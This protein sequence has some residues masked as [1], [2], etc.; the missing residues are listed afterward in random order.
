MFEQRA[1]RRSRL[2]VLPSGLQFWI[3]TGEVTIV[4]LGSLLAFS[5]LVVS[6][7]ILPVG[8]PRG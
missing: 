2:P 6:W 1:R 3:E 7:V 4:L 5:V 8:Q